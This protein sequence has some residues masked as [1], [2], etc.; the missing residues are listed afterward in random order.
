MVRLSEMIEERISLA[1]TM[2]IVDRTES[3]LDEL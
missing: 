1:S 2:R 3:I